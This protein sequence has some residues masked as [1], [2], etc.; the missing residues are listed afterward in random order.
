MKR[1]SQHNENDSNYKMT[2]KMIPIP[3]E[4]FIKFVFQA[5]GEFK[6]K[7]LS[8]DPNPEPN[9]LSESL[10]ITNGERTIMIPHDIQNEA[11]TMYLKRDQQL[12]AM[13]GV[14][15][16]LDSES[17]YADRK[18]L[19]DSNAFEVETD[20]DVDEQINTDDGY[21]EDLEKNSSSNSNAVLIA[22]CIVTVLLLIYMFGHKVKI[23]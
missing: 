19:V 16:P 2:G 14:N 5:M 21:T 6:E 12:K 20:D 9:P 7:L 10:F 13:I 1:Y 23:E 8:G 11:I 3:K 15:E 18:P 4:E 17:E 22:L